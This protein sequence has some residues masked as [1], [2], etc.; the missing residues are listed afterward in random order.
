MGIELEL[1]LL[2]EELLQHGM[3][4]TANPDECMD[5]YTYDRWVIVGGQDRES[6]GGRHVFP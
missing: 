1:G 2:Y 4:G 6:M 5:E 3:Q